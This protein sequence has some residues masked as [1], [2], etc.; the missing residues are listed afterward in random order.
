MFADNVLVLGI[1]RSGPAPTPLFVDGLDVD[2]HEP[3]K[4]KSRSGRE[5]VPG[6]FASQQN[7]LRTLNGLTALLHLAAALAG[8]TQGLS[9]YPGGAG[10]YS[11]DYGSQRDQRDSFIYTLPR[12]GRPTAP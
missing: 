6:N 8:R 2:T 5:W 1:D 11:A 3:V 7:L 10:F 4:W 12:R 9:A